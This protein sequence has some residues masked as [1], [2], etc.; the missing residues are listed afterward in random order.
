MKNNLYIPP[1][2]IINW[3]GW[4]TDIYRLK[5][6]GW[7]ISARK[8]PCSSILTL[9]IHHKNTKQI[10]IS[11]NLHFNYN[12]Y[13]YNYDLPPNIRVEM[14]F[15][16]RNMMESYYHQRITP[17]VLFHPIDVNPEI[18]EIKTY[19]FNEMVAEIPFKNVDMKPKEIYLH[20]AS[21]NEILDIA[22]SKQ[23][24]KQKE[25]RNRML[26]EKYTI[27]S[28]LEAELRLVK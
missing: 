14:H 27:H 9:A 11:E 4:T 12:D 20:Q 8:D 26:N 13:N 1:N 15:N 2:F 24:P 7:D 19:T 25:I 6:N 21:M 10:G 23:E 16:Q 22:L 18:R 3:E 5:A 17:D 28:K